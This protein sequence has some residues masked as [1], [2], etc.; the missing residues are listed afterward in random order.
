MK[1]ICPFHE[2]MACKYD[3]SKLDLSHELQIFKDPSKF[4][5]ILNF[6]VATF[7]T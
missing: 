3:N 7:K 2:F 6:L 5:K 4:L 1:E